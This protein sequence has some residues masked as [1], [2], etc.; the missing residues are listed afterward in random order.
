MDDIDEDVQTNQISDNTFS[1]TNMLGTL[2][3]MLFAN[4]GQAGPNK[5]DDLDTQSALTPQSPWANV[6]SVG[7]LCQRVSAVFIVPAL[8][9]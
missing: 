4:A 7:K 3:T 6:I 9:N 2:M 5:S 8:M 1:W